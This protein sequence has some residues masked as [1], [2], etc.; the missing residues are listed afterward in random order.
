MYHNISGLV[1]VDL[2]HPFNSYAHG[3]HLHAALILIFYC[4]ASKLN[5]QK[6]A[7][8]ASL[9]IEAIC[10]F[11]RDRIYHSIIMCPSQHDRQ[12]SVSTRQTAQPLTSI[13]V[14][15]NK[16]KTAQFNFRVLYFFLYI[17]PRFQDLLTPSRALSAGLGL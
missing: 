7:P 9:P 16:I 1:F 4:Q 5:I 12:V 15:I 11:F 10:I 8:H 6:Q 14:K 17:L 13:A 3:K 2:I